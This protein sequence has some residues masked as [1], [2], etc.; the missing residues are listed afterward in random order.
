MIKKWGKSFQRAHHPSIIVIYNCSRYKLFKVL[1][2]KSALLPFKIEQILLRK[3][4]HITALQK[5]TFFAFILWFFSPLYY[6]TDSFQEYP[7]YNQVPLILIRL[8]E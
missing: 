5:L 8:P 7:H 6:S 1:K 2:L 3:C 4:I